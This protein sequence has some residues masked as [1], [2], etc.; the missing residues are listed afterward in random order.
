MW[1]FVLCVIEGQ[2][3]VRRSPPFLL[4]FKVA[5]LSRRHSHVMLVLYSHWLIY[6][7]I[8]FNFFLNP[9][10][11]RYKIYCYKSDFSLLYI[12]SIPLIFTTHI[13]QLSHF[14]VYLNN[15][16]AKE[17]Q[18]STSMCAWWSK[19][20]LPNILYSFIHFP[21]DHFLVFTFVLFCIAVN[22]LPLCL[23]WRH[24]NMFSIGTG[25]YLYGSNGASI[26][27]GNTSWAHLL[28]ALTYNN[29]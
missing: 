14:L 18:S 16:K 5:C 6:P 20:Y 2:N 17:I 12:V 1:C 9:Y 28:C 29:L 19:Q 7:G 21:L 24:V 22:V 8:W 3:I 4:Q 10:F 15:D 26:L 27:R 13:S 23:T 11:W 25:T